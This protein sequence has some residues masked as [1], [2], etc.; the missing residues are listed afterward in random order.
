MVLLSAVM[1]ASW[2]ALLKSG[3]DRL[4][5]ITVMAV[6]A[7]AVTKGNKARASQ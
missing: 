4:R 6:S 2:N 5:G 3:G 7:G 1:H